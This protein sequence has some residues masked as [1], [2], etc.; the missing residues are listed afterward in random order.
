MLLLFL[1]SGGGY[2]TPVA[3]PWFKAE[4]KLSPE[5]GVAFDEYISRPQVSVL[6]CVA[7][8]QVCNPAAGGPKP[9]NSCIPLLFGLEGSEIGIVSA[10]LSLT[11]VQTSVLSR[12]FNALNGDIAQILLALGGSSLLAAQSFD[13]TDGIGLPDH[14][15]ILELRHSF[16]VL[17]TFIQLR[18]TQYVTGTGNPAENHYLQPPTPR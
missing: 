2:S 15:W 3:D 18:I 4:T 8:T 12:F 10:R 16:S 5:Y 1:A 13:G 11:P 14:Q 6:G 7:Q 9:E 17:L